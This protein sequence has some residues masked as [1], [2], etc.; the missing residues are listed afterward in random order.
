ML[1]PVYCCTSCLNVPT[2]PTSN[3]YSAQ[4]FVD[5]VR[6]RKHDMGVGNLM[7]VPLLEF[8]D[9]ASSYNEETN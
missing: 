5:H 8:L 9:T 2:L 6:D 3:S 7:R 4:W 1:H